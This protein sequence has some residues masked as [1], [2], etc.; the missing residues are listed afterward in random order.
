M[1]DDMNGT[2][3]AE[4][5]PVSSCANKGKELRKLFPQ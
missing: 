5:F 2:T 4:E 3:L 1:P